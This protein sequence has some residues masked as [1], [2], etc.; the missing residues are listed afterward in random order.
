MTKAEIKKRFSD[1]NILELEEVYESLVSS[2]LLNADF[3]RWDEE[4]GSE[5]E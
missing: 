5:I 2:L 1:Y 4:E 3:R